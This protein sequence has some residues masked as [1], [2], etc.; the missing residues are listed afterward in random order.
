MAYQIEQIKQTDMQEFTIDQPGVGGLNIADIEYNTLVTQSPDMLNMMYRNGTLAKRFGQVAL[1]TFD[2]TVYAMA[3][4]QNDLY[5]HSGDTIFKYVISTGETTTVKEDMPKQKGM[6]INFNRYLYYLCNK[7]F[8]QYDGTTWKEVEPYAPDVVINRKPDGSEADTIE[9]YNRYGNAFKNTFNGDGTSK[10]YHLTDKDL[11]E[12]T[13][14]ITVDEKELASDQFSVNYETG[15]VTFT[16]APSKGQNNVVITAYKTD[17]DTSDILMSCTCWKNYG[18]ANNS[19]LFL[20]GNGKS[21]YY[22]SEVFDASYFPENN[23]ATVG[24]PEEDIVGFGD[25]YDTLIVL[26]PHEMSSV[27]YSSDDEGN[28]TFSSKIVNTEMGCDCPNSIQL[29]D[30]RLTWLSTV[31]GACCLESTYI[32]DE[33]NVNAISRNVNGNEERKG[34]LNEEDLT[35]CVCFKFDGRYFICCPSGHCYMWDYTNSP[36]SRNGDPDGSAL[37]LAWFLFDNFYFTCALENDKQLFYGRSNQLCMLS[38]DVFTDFNQTVSCHYQTPILTM[39][40]IDY[41]KQFKYLSVLTRGDM[42]STIKI[43]YMTEEDDRIDE[44]LP[45][46]IYGRLWKWFNWSTFGYTIAIFGRTVTRRMNIKKFMQ[47]GIMF[48]N[49][50]HDSNLALSVIKIR[51]RPMKF[52]R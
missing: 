33:R 51:W 18:G 19:R 23:Y 1:H 17:G 41:Y 2:E 11:D 13:P 3:K 24:N 15:V 39:S 27:N 49:D 16:T 37:K 14:K 47:L 5:I 8:W 7:V 10:E 28:F 25:Q 46:R 20:A 9:D 52:I 43:Y 29:L 42:A 12:V 40:Q 6:F 30:N 21:M 34:L 22:Y 35:E 38:L 36:W 32:E 48:Y 4:Y 45:I 44:P 50:E 31:F 26:K